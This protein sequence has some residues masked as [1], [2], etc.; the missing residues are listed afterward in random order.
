MSK[1]I[2]DKFRKDN[3]D[4]AQYTQ[5]IKDI[6]A[7]GSIEKGRNGITKVLVGNIMYFDLTENTLPLLTTKKLHGNL[8]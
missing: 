6:L 8:V 7:N 5:L 4:E 3:G 1:S 2:I